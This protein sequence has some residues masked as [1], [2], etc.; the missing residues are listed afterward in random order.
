[1]MPLKFCEFEF[2]ECCLEDSI[3]MLLPSHATHVLQPLDLGLSHRL[4]GTAP[5][6]LIT[7]LL[8]SLCMPRTA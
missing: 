1:M 2:C 6:R 7:K 3:T 4:T 8:F 5:K